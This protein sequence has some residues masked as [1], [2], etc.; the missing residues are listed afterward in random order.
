MASKSKKRP[1][2]TC[3]PGDDARRWR[4]SA[5]GRRDLTSLR[6]LPRALS[7]IE[8]TDIFF[9]ATIDS[10]DRRFAL[11]TTANLPLPMG[12]MSSYLLSIIV[13]G[14]GAGS[15][16]AVVLGWAARPAARTYRVVRSLLVSYVS[17]A[18]ILLRALRLASSV[19]QT[20]IGLHLI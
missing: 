18:R 13:C 16:M 3:S 8:S 19:W 11:C 6:H 2:T 12:L 1:P 15:A 17:L 10:S 9:T 5:A 14:C 20:K 4:E 7:S